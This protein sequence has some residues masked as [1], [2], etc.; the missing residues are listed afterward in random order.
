MTNEIAR[1]TRSLADAMPQQND[2]KLKDIVRS[3]SVDCEHDCDN[4]GGGC[5][6]GECQCGGGDCSCEQ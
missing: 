6:C 2:I 5:S 1:E 3:N 4:C